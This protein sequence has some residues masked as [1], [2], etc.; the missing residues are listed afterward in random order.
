MWRYLEWIW[1]ACKTEAY[2]QFVIRARATWG[3]D[4]RRDARGHAR[5]HARGGSAGGAGARPYVD[6]ITLRTLT[7]IKFSLRTPGKQLVLQAT[8]IK[9]D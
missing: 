4:G 5:G 3:A 7:L 6:S 8:T 2:D 1:S 9:G